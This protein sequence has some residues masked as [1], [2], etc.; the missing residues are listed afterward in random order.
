MVVTALI[1]LNGAA[2]RGLT[3]VTGLSL[4]R[5]IQGPSEG[6]AAG[7]NRLNESSGSYNFLAMASTVVLACR[8]QAKVICTA[9]FDV[10]LEEI[11]TVLNAAGSG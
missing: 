10:R 4:L 1:K 11:D 3:H 7:T 6:S 8:F 5:M 2:H 9:E